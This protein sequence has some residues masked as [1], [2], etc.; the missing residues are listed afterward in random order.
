MAGIRGEL[1]PDVVVEN[2]AVGGLMD[3]R[4]SEVHAVPLDGVGDAADEDHCAVRFDPFDDADVGE[5]VIPFSISVEVPGV[6]KK[7]QVSGLG[8]RPLVDDALSAYM[9]INEPDAVCIGIIGVGVIEI[10][11][12]LQEDG[13]CDTGAVVGDPSAFARDRRRT[14]EGGRRPYDRRSAG[15]RQ[16]GWATGAV[17]RDRH[18]R[19]L[20]RHG[21][22]R[23]FYRWCC[24]ADQGDNGDG[25]YDEKES[26]DVTVR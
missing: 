17:C 10:D 20:V 6:V 9:V 16:A 24:A 2:T 12:V 22:L 13:A 14:Y 26:H 23:G 8:C 15:A 5:R 4:V 1:A 21:S 7:H 25:P 19:R 18:L 11:A 3:Q